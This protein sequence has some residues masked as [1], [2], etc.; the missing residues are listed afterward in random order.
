MSGYDRYITIFSPEGRLFQIEYAFKAT[1]GTDHTTVALRGEKCVALVTQKKVVDKLIDPSSV[2]HMFQI[3]EKI[4][5]VMTGRSSDAKALVTQARAEASEFR[6]NNGYAMPCSVLAKRMADLAQVYTQQAGRRA[7]A[8]MMILCSIDEEQ[9]PSL[10][11]VDPAGHFFGYKAVAA[12]TKFQEAMTRLEKRVKEK[13]DTENDAS[14]TDYTIQSAIEELQHVLSA[15]FKP[16]EI[17]VG[18]VEGS[19]NFRTLSEEEIENHLT[20]IS[21]RD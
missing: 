9:G 1:R 8:A 11:K 10:Y 12:G 15:D 18:L 14:D 13:R 6:Y 21:Q 17:E 4:G 20:A 16:T 19:N 7:Y 5:A 3:T 2:T